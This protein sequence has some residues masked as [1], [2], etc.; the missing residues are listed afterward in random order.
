MEIGVRGAG[1]VDEVRAQARER[2]RHK[3]QDLM[4]GKGPMK[5]RT[6]EGDVRVRWL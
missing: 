5:N 6:E 1:V 2:I 4:R 3:T